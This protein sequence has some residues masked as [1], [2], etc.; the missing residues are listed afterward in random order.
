M[1]DAS[2]KS[3]GLR[4]RVSTAE[5]AETHDNKKLQQLSMANAAAYGELKAEVLLTSVE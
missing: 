1:H 4:A 5:G 2:T 3:G